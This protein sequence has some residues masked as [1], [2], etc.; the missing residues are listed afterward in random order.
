MSFAYKTVATAVGLPGKVSQGWYA[1][2]GAVQLS[3]IHLNGFACLNNGSFGNDDNIGL[4][5]KME[6]AVSLGSP[7]LKVM[8][9]HSS[10][11]K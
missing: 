5:V 3:P 8:G 2:S 11:D 4:A 1:L 10:G 9:V 6:A 7:T